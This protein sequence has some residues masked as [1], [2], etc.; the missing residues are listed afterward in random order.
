[1]EI[2]CILLC[3]REKVVE[4]FEHYIIQ[5][6]FL[7]LKGR[8]ENLVDVLPAYYENNIRLF[9]VDIAYK[10]KIRSF[11]SYQMALP[12]MQFIFLADNGKDA[13]DCFRLDALDYILI[14]C[15]YSIFLNAAGKAMRWFSL[16]KGDMQKNTD[17]TKRQTY[18][19]IRSEHRILRIDFDDIEYIEGMGDYVKIYQ[20]NVAKPTLCLCSLKNMEQA[21]PLDLFMRVHRSF[22]IHKYNIHVLERGNI[23]MGKKCIPIG[24]RYR[25][26]VKAFLCQFPML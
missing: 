17:K 20:R 23:I 4:K 6:T 12:V 18:I 25:E 24:E 10:D 19:Y 14:D 11:L 7:T 15:D 5:T 13:V 26:Q 8:F 9:F 22:I 21:L 3:H 16:L 2:E 1:M